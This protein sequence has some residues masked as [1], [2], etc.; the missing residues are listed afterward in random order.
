MV[1]NGTTVTAGTEV[2]TSYLSDKYHQGILIG[3]I[4][5]VETDNNNSTRSGTITPAVNFSRLETVL[6]ITEQKE[7]LDPEPEE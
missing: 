4:K 7:Q 2:V 5:D 1:E 3:Y 6:V